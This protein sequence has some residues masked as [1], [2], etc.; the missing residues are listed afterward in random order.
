[1][2]SNDRD[3]IESQHA[4]KSLPTR[5]AEKSL[6]LD[7]YLRNSLQELNEF[8][9]KAMGVVVASK[10]G[11]P[12][13][14]GLDYR[15][16]NS[17]RPPATWSQSYETGSAPVKRQKKIFPS[18]LPYLAVAIIC[19][20]G[21]GG[22]L[23]YFLLHFAAPHADVGGAHSAAPAIVYDEAAVGSPLQQT[24]S[25][26][27]P[28]RAALSFSGAE[29]QSDPTEDA[30]GQ[31]RSSA[32]DGK[33]AEASSAAGFSPFADSGGKEAGVREASTASKTA[34][35]P[36]V[37]EAPPAFAAAP[38]ELRGAKSSDSEKR[39]AQFPKLPAD[40]EDK[41]LKRAS[42]L[43]KENDIAGAR[44]IFQ[45]LANHGSPKGAFALAETYDPKKWAGRRVAGMTPDA[46]AA[47]GWYE[48]A[49]ELG[50]KEAASAL[51][52]EKP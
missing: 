26:K 43:L 49:A 12:P 4:A 31:S 22:V 41:M 35:P 25:L 3:E 27:S 9:P 16:E 29:E 19:G 30:N 8:V 5:T 21:S 44:L 48:R 46:D 50:S 20:A 34:V 42:G 47:R 24:P 39:D 36:P 37:V 7:A 10:L 28:S 33:A 45:Y 15:D 23:L 14:P 40:Q 38:Q 51:H 17:F 32:S 1:M 52:K 6:T 18:I 2:T 11:K 13:M